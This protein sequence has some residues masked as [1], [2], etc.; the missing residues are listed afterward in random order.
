M[1]DEW[2]LLNEI[3]RSDEW[4]LQG[5]SLYWVGNCGCTRFLT[6]ELSD[7]LSVLQQV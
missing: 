4:P 3:L 7:G 5:G 6:V 1:S 2:P